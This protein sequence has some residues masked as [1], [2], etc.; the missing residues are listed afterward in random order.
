MAFDAFLLASRGSFQEQDVED[1]KESPV[2]DFQ[3]SSCSAASVFSAFGDPEPHESA[4]SSLSAFGA[5]SSTPDAL[6]EGVAALK[7]P[8]DIPHFAFPSRAGP[9][10]RDYRVIKLPFVT[11]EELR[12]HCTRGDCWMAI[13]GI[14]YDC[15]DFM[16][17]G[18]MNLLVQYSGQDASVPFHRQH[19]AELLRVL[20]ARL[21]V[22]PLVGAPSPLVPFVAQGALNPETATL[23]RVEHKVGGDWDGC[24]SLRLRLPDESATSGLEPGEHIIV[25]A[26]IDGK[27]IHRAYT[28]VSHPSQQG[29]LDVVVKVYPNGTISRY[30]GGLSV[31]EAVRVKGPG[32]SIRYRRGQIVVNGQSRPVSWLALLGGGSGVTPHYQLARSLVADKADATTAR[33][34]S[35]HRTRASAM[36]DRDFDEL[37]GDDRVEHTL[38]I[39]DP[40]VRPGASEQ[41]LPIRSAA[42]SQQ[43]CLFGPLAVEHVTRV[44]PPDFQDEARNRENGC[45]LLCGPPGFCAH[46]RQLLLSL[47]MVELNILEF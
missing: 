6:S 23:L 46:A 33:V 25:V 35:C 22:G 26:L 9:K 19:N 4:V 30:L 47:G 43:V 10:V 31:G 27:E 24:V 13:D 34:L 45:A 32:G 21:V 12:L 7:I 3:T 29:F 37:S 14:V 16:H 28:P 8:T 38:L 39:T 5:P 42:A 15:S 2:V 11:Q 41:T 1:P 40:R 20:G 17:P 36:L 44:L 18:G